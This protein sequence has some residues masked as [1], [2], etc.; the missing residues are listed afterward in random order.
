VKA[1]REASVR[2][3]KSSSTSRLVTVTGY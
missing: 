1:N 3:E 2:T